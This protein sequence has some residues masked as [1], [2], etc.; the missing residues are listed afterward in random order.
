MQGLLRSNFFVLE[1][2][3]IILR[4]KSSVWIILSFQVADYETRLGSCQTR[5]NDTVQELGREVFFCL[6][7][8]I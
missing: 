8:P 6:R 3:V 7:L 1:S 4:N 2:L 5:A